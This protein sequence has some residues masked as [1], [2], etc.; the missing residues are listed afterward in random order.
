MWP[1]TTLLL[2][3][4]LLLIPPETATS[5]N[6]TNSTTPAPFKKPKTDIYVSLMYSSKS[7]LE[8][9]LPLSSWPK[10]HWYHPHA[11]GLRHHNVTETENYRFFS[12][13][14]ITPTR[15]SREVFQALYE[16]YFYTQAIVLTSELDYKLMDSIA[17]FTTGLSAETPVVSL[18][19][20]HNWQEEAHKAPYVLTPQFGQVFNGRVAVQLIIAGKSQ[21]S[22]MR[23]QKIMVFKERVESS[24]LLDFLDEEARL[25][26]GLPVTDIY[27]SLDSIERIANDVVKDDPYPDVIIVDCALEIFERLASLLIKQKVLTNET[28]VIFFHDYLEINL[29]E[30]LEHLFNANVTVYIFGQCQPEWESCQLFPDE[31][32]GRGTNFS[33]TRLFQPEIYGSLFH[34]VL[35]LT[36]EAGETS[37]YNPNNYSD[38]TLT[39][40][41]VCDQT[42]ETLGLYKLLYFYSYYDYY[43]Y[44][45]LQSY[46]WRIHFWYQHDGDRLLQALK[47]TCFNGKV[48][49]L[50]FSEDALSKCLNMTAV[51]ILP[52]RLTE[53]Y[54]N[55]NETHIRSKWRVDGRW[56]QS[57]GLILAPTVSV[58]SQSEKEKDDEIKILKVLAKRDSLF[59]YTD[60]ESKVQGVDADLLEF[61]AQTAGFSKVEYTLWNETESPS[62]MLKNFSDLGK[63]DM[64]AGAIAVAPEKA[65]FTRSYYLSNVSV[66]SQSQQI[67]S[68][69]YIWNFMD[70]F[71][72]TVWLG[73][74]A[75]LAISTFVVKWLGLVKTFP[76][77]A[78]LS[79][80]TFY[81]MN[82]N[83]L[84][85]M[86]NP[87][88][89]IY[90]H[91]LLFVVLVLVSS[92]TANMVSFLTADSNGNSADFN[93]IS[94]RNRPVAAERE[95]DDL[96]NL[97]TSGLRNTVSVRGEKEA[98]SLLLN[99]TIDAYVADAYLIEML[100]KMHCNLTVIKQKLWR[101]QFA[102]AISHDFSEKYGKVV[103]SAI[104]EAV[105]SFNVS[106][107]LENRRKKLM[108]AN[109]CESSRLANQQQLGLHNVG[110]VFVIAAGGAVICF[111][112]KFALLRSSKRKINP[113]FKAAIN[114]SK[115]LIN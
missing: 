62:A 72:W 58:F 85:Y 32:K 111:L 11:G 83:R 61:I 5:E 40:P 57:E 29:W 6:R 92:Y 71:R 86:R 27:V 43:Y 69:I 74:L 87:F 37:Q 68:V 48:G 91:T 90:I 42:I 88:G 23:L 54:Q 108:P 75:I 93:L 112:S 16:A 67:D 4:I 34:D 51:A 106:S 7:V 1:S 24:T 101:R 8:Q 82:E 20:L 44:Q 94:F 97:Q 102:F 22:K 14:W 52:L 3:F 53:V 76:D 103:G 115:E 31:T 56:T 33:Q 64:A 84:I 47:D 110:G 59:L 98:A 99:E 25:F 38:F 89:R 104:V 70:A 19:P 55:P 109:D 96:A 50:A 73:I 21:N 113:G 49:S 18:I 13:L 79:F 105:H 26:R 100:V 77:A 35:D 107:W 39:I 63:W 78:W 65:N 28:L 80:A 12:R 41:W 45:D 66:T 60:D 9:T 10:V 30:G 95:S 2:Q 46:R 15:N 36:V 114:S 81:F 17:S